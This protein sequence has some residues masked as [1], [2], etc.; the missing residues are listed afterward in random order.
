VTTRHRRPAL[1]Q[2]LEWRPSRWIAGSVTASTDPVDQMTFR[3]Y[4]DQLF[5]IVVNYGHERTAGLT[6]ADVIEAVTRI[7][8]A[9]R[10]VPGQANRVQSAPAYSESGPVIARWA[11]AGHTVALYRTSA[12]GGA[13]RLVV[14]ETA[15]DALAR[16]AESQALR[17]DVTEAP[18]REIEKQKL[19]REREREAA[20]KARDANKPTFRP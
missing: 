10:P 3:F 13:W 18:Q 14:T 4:E 6:D 16:R 12:Y 2:D 17:L 19:E 1:L 20:D 8:G 11:D 7:Y 15:V 5:E 9:A